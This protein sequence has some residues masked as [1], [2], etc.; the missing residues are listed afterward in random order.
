MTQQRI[1][2]PEV[3]RMAMAD[4]R[5]GKLANEEHSTRE[6][7][8]EHAMKR[9][10]GILPDEIRAILV[11]YPPQAIEVYGLLM[12]WQAERGQYPPPQEETTISGTSP[13]S[14]SSE[15]DTDREQKALNTLFG[16]Q[17][18]GSSNTF[19]VNVPAGQ[20]PVNALYQAVAVPL[21][22]MHQLSANTHQPNVTF[23]SGPKMDL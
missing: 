21:A 9:I 10:E 8:L 4:L 15:A 1:P 14:I 13:Q 20:D 7:V 22:A 2:S 23:Q 12:R 19:Q 5:S 16:G 6:E 3:I 17:G 11:Q 18:Q